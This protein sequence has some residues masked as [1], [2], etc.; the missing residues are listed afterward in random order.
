MKGKVWTDEERD[1]ALLLNEQ[2]MNYPEI[3]KELGRTRKSVHTMFA[4]HRA[5]TLVNRRYLVGWKPEHIAE[6]RGYMERGMTNR[7]IAETMQRTYQAVQSKV[8]Y[9]NQF[10]K[11]GQSSRPA[12]EPN[13]SP[14]ATI[15]EWRHRQALNP[16]TITAALMGDPPPGY[17]ALERRA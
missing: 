3:A 13:K 2:G 14:E 12:T 10:D 8:T 6:L 15:S 9:L 4:R 17:S 7:Q 5:G 1:R 11:W 16:R